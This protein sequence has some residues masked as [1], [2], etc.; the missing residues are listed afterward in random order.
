MMSLLNFFKKVSGLSKPVERNVVVDSGYSFETKSLEYMVWYNGEVTSLL[1]LYKNL[2]KSDGVTLGNMF[3]AETSTSASA[4]YIRKMH[5][6]LPKL[7]VDKLAEIAINDMLEPD[8]SD[9]AKTTWEELKPSINLKEKLQTSTKEV[10]SKCDGAFKL[11]WNKELTNLPIVEFYDALHVDF[12]YQQGFLKEVIFKEEFEEDGRKYLLKYQYT[13]GR[14]THSLWEEVEGGYKEITSLLNT[15]YTSELED[16]DLTQFGLGHVILAVPY[17]IKESLIFKGRGESIFHGKLEAFDALDEVLSTWMDSIRDG[18]TKNYL[19]QSFIPIDPNTGGNLPPDPFNKYMVVQDQ[20]DESGKN[21]VKVAQGDIEYNGYMTSYISFLDIALQGVIS[22]STLG[23]DVKKLD[24]AESQREKEKATLYTR[25]AIIQVLE[26]IVPELIKR[27]LYV[28]DIINGVTVGD[29][30]ATVTFGQY[31]NP[32]FETLL[33][34]VGTARERNIISTEWAVD[35]L[36]GD[37]K[38]PEDKKQEVERLKEQMNIQN[39]S[40]QVNLPPKEES[41]ITN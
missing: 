21:E 18:R 12:S 25:D 29:Y 19:P 16:I 23:I 3:W 9:N 17:K 26:Q 10:L 28:N 20:H 31:A 35:E 38:T 13:Y 40:K 37:S 5:S 11:S 24:N 33:D 30:S 8:V 4:K 32:S 41:T 1:S 6:G 36:W 2:N 14:I 22:P 7:I 15:R 27:I 34:T 39:N